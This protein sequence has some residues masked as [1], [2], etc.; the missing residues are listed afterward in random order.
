MRQW[1]A[2]IALTVAGPALAE[3]AGAETGPDNYHAPASTDIVVT[4]PYERS[5]AD[6]LSGVSV[7]SGDALARELRPNIADTIARQPG[8]STTS[9]GP[10]ASR[11]I[12]RGLQGERIRILTDG[13]G[14]FDVSNTSV[15]HAVTINPLTAERVEVL[16]G[17]ASLQYGSS[18]IGGVVN[19]I[20]RR[21]PRRM[22][23]DG[24]HVDL[25]GTLGS[26]ASERSVGGGVDLA[27]SDSIVVHVDSSYL[28]T[29]DL[30]IGGFV[31]SEPLR[32]RALTSPDSAVRDLASLRGRL[33]NS[34]ARSWDVAGAAAI[35][36]DTGNLGVSVSRYESNYGVPIRYSLDPG[37]EGEAV[38]LDVGQTRADMRGEVDLGS[39]FFSSVRTRIGWADYRHVEL[40]P[41]GSAGTLFTNDAAEGRI[42]LAQAARGGWRGAVGGQ[43]LVRNFEAIGE[44][45][46]VPKSETQQFGLFALQEVSF[47]RVRLE[48]GGR[49]ERTTAE[50]FA[51]AQLGNPDI[52]RAF[53]AFS[54]SLGL[55]VGEEGG[56]KA[57]LNLS[58]TERAPSAEELFANGPH[59]G[60]QAFEV[61][62]PGFGKE[63]SW[64]V[65]AVLRGRASGFRLEASAYYNWFSD[66][67]YQAATGEIVDGLPVYA[68]RQADA[69]YRGFE[70]EASAGLGRIGGVDVVADG[71]VDY[72]RA[73]IVGVGPAPRIPPLR[74]L[75]GVEG[76]GRLLTGRIE[77]ERAQPQRRISDFETPTAGFTMLNA[78]LSW[79][80]LG[81]DGRASL[82]LS[83]NNL[84]DV[85]ARRHPSFLKD[86]APLAG[87]DIRLTA[88]LAF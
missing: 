88:R 79:R 3:G 70:V 73:T 46:F 20:D 49:Y 23:D 85:D 75:G 8:V 50:A 7:L 12:L 26:A 19:V 15:D 60:T 42:E 55:G 16:R 13:I 5:R 45:K 2:V 31:L 32:A 38:R 76:Q 78:S 56:W 59:A 37:A 43:F 10:N 58:R 40:E 52:R 48:L 39:G 66:F 72:V 6:L 63:R 4:A 64:G 28:R 62:D 65:E 21:I 81:E 29:D 54:G 71:L 53:N 74:F 41:D 44:E 1:V 67:I 9:F 24:I 27:L 17:P 87:R 51:D 14:S 30:R 68:F 86:F 47:G 25:I 11:P 84:L 77:V 33:P 34:S 61:G 18:A 35:I 80:P 57:G 22:P 83:G 69:R 36:T 82:V